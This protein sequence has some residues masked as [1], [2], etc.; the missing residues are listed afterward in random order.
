M[1]NKW[2]YTEL[3]NVLLTGFYTS[4]LILFNL[5]NIYFYYGYIVTF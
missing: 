3:H 4:S 5:M 1:H 2:V